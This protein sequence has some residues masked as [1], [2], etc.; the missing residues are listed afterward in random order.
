MNKKILYAI[1]AGLLLGFIVGFLIR[2]P[3]AI[4]GRAYAPVI[5]TGLLGGLFIAFLTEKYLSKGG[6]K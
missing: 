4:I 1:L 5:W 3:D 2:L 6:E